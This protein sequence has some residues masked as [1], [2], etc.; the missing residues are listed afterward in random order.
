MLA[1]KTHTPALGRRRTRLKSYQVALLAMMIPGLLYYIVYRYLPMY[2]V[3]IAFK[4]F[5]IQKGILASPW[6][7]PLLKHFQYFFSSP[8]S[9]QVLTNTVVISFGKIAFHTVSCI[10]L[11]VLISEVRIPWFK[12]TVQTIT[13]LPHFLSWVIVYG[14][15]YAIVSESSGLVNVMLRAAGRHT[16]PVLTNEG[17]FRWLLIL[18]DVWKDAG[19]GGIIYLAAIAGIDPSLYEAAQID[20]AGRLRRIW[21]ITLSGIRPTIIVMLILRMGSV[22]DAGFD[23]IYNLYNP[24][25][26]AVADVIDTWVY[27]TG[28]E[29][30]NFSLATAV[31]L[32]KSVISMVLLVSVNAVARRW[33][34]SLW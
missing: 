30:M 4:D 24:Q 21:H 9:G 3:L 19:W 32:F 33:E 7:D 20:G 5:R 8:Y 18:S 11:A 29:Q 10:V 14:I 27:R 12:R 28:L 31:G 16:V 25:V 26:Y 2:G 13:Y 6:A 22:M 1:Q 23:Q 17:V 34:E 15:L